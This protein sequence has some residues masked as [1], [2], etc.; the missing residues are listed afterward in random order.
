[1]KVKVLISIEDRDFFN[2][3]AVINVIN[4]LF[5]SP[6]TISF[7][8]PGPLVYG[9]ERLYN[10]RFEAEME[11]LAIEDQLL[12]DNEVSESLD[13]INLVLW[14]TLYELA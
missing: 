3:E 8:Y 14:D 13:E 9:I 12:L 5:K 10:V 11:S 1:M 6:T 4:K 2:E 7:E